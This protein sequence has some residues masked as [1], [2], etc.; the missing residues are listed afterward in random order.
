MSNQTLEQAQADSIAANR[1]YQEA[2]AHC[3][4][5]KRVADDLAKVCAELFNAKLDRYD[6]SG[7]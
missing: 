2:Y 4:K 3:L 7:Y 1:A 6:R 5:L